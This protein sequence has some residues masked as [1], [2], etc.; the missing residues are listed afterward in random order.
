MVYIEC[1]I[2]QPLDTKNDNDMINKPSK[3]VSIQ[4]TNERKTPRKE[5]K[6]EIKELSMKRVFVRYAPSRRREE[7]RRQKIRQGRPD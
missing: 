4:Y 7:K 6:Q 2:D 1:R 5:K 3:R